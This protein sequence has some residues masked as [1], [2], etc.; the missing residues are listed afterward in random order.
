MNIARLLAAL[1]IVILGVAALAAC[2][3]EAA[4]GAPMPPPAV[5]VAPVLVQEVA[6]W[7]E[8][9]GRVEAVETVD[10][11]PRVSGYIERVNYTE[12]QEV[13]EGDVLFVIDQRPYRAALARA[14]ADLARARAQAG[15]AQTEAA[16]A[17]KLAEQRAISTEELDQ[18]EAAVAQARAEVDAAEAAA[19]IARLDLEFTE[20]RS[21]IDGRAGRALVTA[22]NLVSTQPNATLL[23]TIV[24]LDP[25]YVYFEGDERTYLRYNAMARNGERPSSRE[26]RSPVRVGLATDEGYP[27]SGYV[28][29]MDNRVDPRTGTIRARAV[30][31]ND[32]H[33]FTPG[34]F[35]RVQLLG[36]GKFEALLV[37]EKAVLT[38]QDRKY[39]YVLGPENRA[40]RKDIVPG[41]LAEG[42][43]VVRE[44]LDPGDRVIVHGVQKVFFPGM[45]VDPQMIGMGDPPPRLAS[46]GAS[47]EALR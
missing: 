47:T 25:V 4:P 29:F 35:A 40:V 46:G 38:D 14:E 17:R 11:K 24:S 6:R 36:S 5:S 31:E 19:D 12:G 26:A 22:G 21:P 28:D 34:L 43:R 45:P 30:L 10:L 33:V 44:G 42:L 15:L 8:Y 39:V 37:D 2:T 13:A 20:V 27:Y 1:A 41:D 7:D 9:T 32:D 18:R 23:T 3:G 16:R